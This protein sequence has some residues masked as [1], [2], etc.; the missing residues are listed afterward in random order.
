MLIFLLSSGGWKSGI[1]W[2]SD[3]YRSYRKGG[4][5][6]ERNENHFLVQNHFHQEPEAP[7][8]FPV[9][10][11]APCGT[12][13]RAPKPRKNTDKIFPDVRCEYGAICNLYR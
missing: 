1:K 12:G 5:H 4:G 3:C 2:V 10:D 9:L 8:P 6:P 7:P 11:E 13:T